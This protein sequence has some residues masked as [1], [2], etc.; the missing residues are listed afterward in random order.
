[1]VG[2]TNERCA[3]LTRK[4]LLEVLKIQPNKQA[5]MMYVLQLELEILRKKYISYKETDLTVFLEFT[6]SVVCPG[7]ALDVRTTKS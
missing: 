3:N 2:A 5:D 4:M 6:A 7:D 1:M